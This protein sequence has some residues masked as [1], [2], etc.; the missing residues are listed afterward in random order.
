MYEASKDFEVLLVECCAPCHNDPESAIRVK[1]ALEIEYDTNIDVTDAIA[2][3]LDKAASYVPGDFE[4]IYES[5]LQDIEIENFGEKRK[6]AY[7]SV[8]NVILQPHSIA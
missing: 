3:V 7:E 1:Q 8:I 2:L 6:K 5:I 4:A